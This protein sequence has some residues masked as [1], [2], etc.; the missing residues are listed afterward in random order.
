MKWVK[1]ENDI[2]LT[3]FSL[4]KIPSRTMNKGRPHSLNRALGEL[5]SHYCS[6]IIEIDLVL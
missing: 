4:I 3:L 2:Y 6:R 5:N 1:I